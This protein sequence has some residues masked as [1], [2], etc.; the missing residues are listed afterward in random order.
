MFS[1]LS[2]SLDIQ[3]QQLYFFGLSLLP[4]WCHCSVTLLERPGAL[5]TWQEGCPPLPS[6]GGSAGV[7]HLQGPCGQQVGPAGDKRPSWG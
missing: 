6:L 3:A 4:L 1:A 2:L 7:L 5:L